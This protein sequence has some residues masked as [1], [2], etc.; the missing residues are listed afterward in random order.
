MSFLHFSA[1]VGQSLASIMF[2][3]ARIRFP[4][5]E[6]L[7]GCRHKARADK[8]PACV[9]TTK[10]VRQAGQFTQV[11]HANTNS[12]AAMNLFGRRGRL[13]HSAPPPKQSAALHASGWSPG[14]IAGKRH[15]PGAESC[16]GKGCCVIYCPGPTLVWLDCPA[17]SGSWPPRNQKI[18]SRANRRN[19]V[20]F[21]LPWNRD[22][23]SHIHTLVLRLSLV[24]GDQMPDIKSV[25]SCC[26]CWQE[27]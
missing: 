2:P 5:E 25:T 11:S 4:G 3:T 8:R 18:Q 17:L 26:R 6:A 20:G 16:C 23:G 12:S 21:C 27:R 15:V 14:A 9:L 13:R 7:L 22:A 19:A 10:Q 24:R 1:I